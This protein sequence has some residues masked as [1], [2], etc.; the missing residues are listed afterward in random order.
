MGSTLLLVDDED[1]L[2]S[3]L[4]AALRY[5]GYEV[6]PVADGAAALEAAAT[7][8]PDA[9][10][11]DVMLPG[12]GFEACRQL[13]DRGDRVPIVFLTAVDSPAETTISRSLSASRS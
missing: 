7:H 5:N 2:R 8:R 6:I 1:H 4:G 13:R 10:V 11:L 12:I 9:I 3:M